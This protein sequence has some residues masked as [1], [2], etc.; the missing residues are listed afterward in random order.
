MKSIRAFFDSRIELDDDLWQLF[1]ARVTKRSYP[2]N[3]T[4][5]HVGTTEN[6]LSFVEEGVVRSY[7]PNQGNDIT[8]DL[9]F[10]NQFVSAYDSFLKRIPATYKLETLAPTSLISIT[11]DDLQQLYHQRKIGNIIGRLASENIFERSTGYFL[12]KL[13]C[14]PEEIYARLRREQGALLDLVPHVFL[15]SYL[16]VTVPTLGRIAANYQGSASKP[17]VEATS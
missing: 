4:L 14:T 10:P 9:A 11:F 7:I 2:A 6:H 13:N 16:G 1:V 3:T 17:S 5:I 8:F 12:D 15:A